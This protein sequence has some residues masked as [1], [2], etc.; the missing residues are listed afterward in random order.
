MAWFE[1]QRKS[2]AKIKMDEA[3]MILWILWEARNNLCWNNKQNLSAATLYCAKKELE[4]WRSANTGA[5][6][7]V[8][9]KK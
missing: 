9:A 5:Q 7:T 8:V 1:G 2:N 4:E 6:M 3:I